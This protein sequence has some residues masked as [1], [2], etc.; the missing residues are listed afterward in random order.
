MYVSRSETSPV[1]FAPTELLTRLK[2]WLK[3][4]S[5]DAILEEFE[6]AEREENE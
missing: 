5:A 3:R 1:I 4:F 2:A 6:K